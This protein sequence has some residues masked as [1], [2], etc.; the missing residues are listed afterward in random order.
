M[1]LSANRKRTIWR[2]PPD[3]SS[4]YFTIQ[5]LVN[6]NTISLRNKA[7]DIKPVLYYSANNGITWDSITAVKGSTLPIATL[8]TNETLIFKCNI[9]ALASAWDNYNGFMTTGYYKV[10]GNI[11]SLLYGDNFLDKEEFATSSKENFSGLFREN[12]GLTDARNL[13]MPCKKLMSNCYNGTFRECPSL[14]T[15][16]K[17]PATTLANDCYSSMFEGCFCLS[18][19][20]ELPATTLM[21][22]CYRRMFLMSRTTTVTSRLT[23]SP[24]LAANTLVEG[25]YDEMFK[26]NGSIVQVTC[27]ATNIT[28]G[29]PNWLMNVS[30][31]GEFIKSEEMNSWPRTVNGIPSGWTV[32]NATLI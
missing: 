25:C 11:M 22:K 17:L 7:C 8:N 10:Y 30:Q 3:Y 23:K 6:N 19:A 28:K 26:G 24:V 5:S 20:P 15:A 31:T 12:N 18:E 29:T 2:M 9:K 16:P 32:K 13:I 27:L 14:I 4:M 21:S 1:E